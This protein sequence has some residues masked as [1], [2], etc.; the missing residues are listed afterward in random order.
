MIEIVLKDCERR[1]NHYVCLCPV[2]KEKTPSFTFDLTK[3]KY[4]CFGCGISGDISDIKFI[5]QKIN[6][7]VITNLDYYLDLS[8][9]NKDDYYRSHFSILNELE[10]SVK[11]AK[12]FS[13]NPSF[14]Y[15]IGGVEIFQFVRHYDLNGIS[16]VEY[17][18]I[19]GAS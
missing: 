13:R 7:L 2:H 8:R 14:D 16:I 18:Y 5:S 10:N 4:K 17:E 1:G 11:Y 15:K 6:H 19:G 3:D 12:K 9:F